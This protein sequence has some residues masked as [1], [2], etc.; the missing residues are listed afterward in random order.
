MRTTLLLATTV[1]FAL[2]TPVMADS[3]GTMSMPDGKPMMTQATGYRFE[4]VGTAQM[5]SPGV[6]RVTVRLV[7]AGK[8]ITS[9]TIQTSRADMGPEGMAAMTAPI[10]GVP[11]A[12]PG[13]F[14]FDIQYGGVWN[15]PAKW[16]LSFSAKVQGEMQPVTGTVTVALGS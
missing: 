10:K 15:K 6:A 16:M 12:A 3:M 1:L 9:A 7:K 2:A 4:Q 8:P 5:P 11:G 14:M 13:T